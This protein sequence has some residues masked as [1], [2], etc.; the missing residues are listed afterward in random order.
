MVRPIRI[1]GSDVARAFRESLEGRARRLVASDRQNEGDDL[2]GRVNEEIALSLDH[3]DRERSLHERR[4]RSLLR[5]ECYTDTEL[6]QMEQRTPTYSPYRFPEREKLQRRLL[7]IE[8]ERRR[9]AGEHEG[10][11]QALHDRLLELLHKRA[12][13]EF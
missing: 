5:V 8:E 11:L 12:Q 2:A 6:I 1:Q 4:L 9:L 10:K 3:L 7:R 13:L